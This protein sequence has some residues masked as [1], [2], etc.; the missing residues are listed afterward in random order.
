LKYPVGIL[1]LVISLVIGLALLV[2]MAEMDR[3]YR[4]RQ[5]EVKREI[6]KNMSKNTVMI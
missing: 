5:A 3:D 2:G 6:R 4:K 1:P